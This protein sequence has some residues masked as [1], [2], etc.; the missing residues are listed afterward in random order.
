MNTPQ[1]SQAAFVC[2]DLETTGCVGLSIHDPYNRIV[3]IAAKAVDSDETFEELVNPECHI[4][5]PSSKIHKL[6]DSDVADA[7]GLGCVLPRFKQ[8]C[9]RVAKGR[10][11][12]L[13]AHNGVGFDWP[14]LLR[15]ARRVGKQRAI[16]VPSAHVCTL[17]AA[18]TAWPHLK[19]FNL[20][21]LYQTMSGETLD[22]AHNAAADV[23]ACIYLWNRLQEAG[24]TAQHQI[25]SS[26]QND[27]TRVLNLKWIGPRTANDLVRLLN[28]KDYVFQR[29]GS[30]LTIGDLRR[31]FAGQTPSDIEA[32][33]RCLPTLRED[34]RILPILSAVLGRDPSQVATKMP[35]VTYHY[36]QFSPFFPTTMR[37]R[38]CRDGVRT[39]SSLYRAMLFHFDSTDRLVQY[40]RTLGLCD[41][42]GFRKTWNAFLLEFSC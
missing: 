23:R 35:F 20:A 19:A 36:G 10:P 11:L 27:E 38:L 5:T 17:T 42:A 21:S 3:Q 6:T 8:W 26:A 32:T 40:L 37:R 1:T 16:P 7:P 13:I 18:R 15:E 2:W 12:V 30:T 33:L 28:Q 31:F 34:R 25:T 24:S 9:D 39:P 29:L 41:E 22:N 4:P 14:V